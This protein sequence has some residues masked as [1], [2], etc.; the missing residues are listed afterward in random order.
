MSRPGSRPCAGQPKPYERRY[1]AYVTSLSKTYPRAKFSF[2]VINSAIELVHSTAKKH[3]P[4]GSIHL[5]ITGQDRRVATGEEAWT[6]DTDEEFAAEYRKEGTVSRY[7]IQYVLGTTTGVMLALDTSEFG[8]S[9]QIEAF[10]RSEVLRIAGIFDDKAAESTPPLPAP[11]LPMPQ[12]AP[13]VF[14]GHGGAPD[15]QTLLIDLQKHDIEVQAFETGARAG[16]TIRDILDAELRRTDLA[17]LVLTGED[18][19]AGGQLRARQN[20]VHEAGLF[21][22]KLGWGRAILLIQ[23]G[24]EEFSNAAGV[25]HIKFSQGKISGVVGEVLAILRREKLM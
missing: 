14:I 5:A 16:H 6:F 23:E 10:E 1:H 8:T 3:I 19:Q 15:W 12:P 4:E 2:A 9:V 21:Q 17:L 20:V 18:E 7:R 22:G 25:I 13:R 11:P 24:V